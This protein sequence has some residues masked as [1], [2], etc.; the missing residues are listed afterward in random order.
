VYERRRRPLKL[1]IH[2]DILVA[3]DG[4]VTLQELRRVPRYYTGSA[5]YLHAIGAG[6]LSVGLDGN[7]TRVPPARSGIMNPK[8]SGRK[9]ARR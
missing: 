2:H 9:A 5:W 1:G 6:A 8:S 3:L 4:A 7:P